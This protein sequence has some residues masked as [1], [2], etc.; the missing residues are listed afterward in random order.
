[1]SLSSETR[2]FSYTFLPFFKFLLKRLGFWILVLVVGLNLV[3]FLPRLMPVSPV[4]IFLT[5]VLGGVGGPGLTM[6]G[7]GGGAA[8]A[9]V[10][11]IKARFMEL[12]GLNQP[13]AIQYLLFWKRMLTLDF[14]IS[15]IE[16]P[17]SVSQVVLNALP[18]TL[19]LIIPALIVGFF[20]GT[21]LG[22]IAAVRPSKLKNFVFYTFVILLQTPYY[23][24][25]M[26]FLYVFAVYFRIF[27]IKGAFSEKWVEPV[28][29]WEFFVDVLW[30]YVLPF[31]T[32]CIPTI[33][34]YAAGMR[35]AVASETRSSYVEFC[36]F[37]GFSQKRVMRYI[38]RSAILPNLTWFPLTFVGLISQTLLVEIVFGYPGLGFY[39]YLAAFSLDYPLME[40]LFLMIMLIVVFG[41]LIIELLYGLLNPKIGAAYVSE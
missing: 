17:K 35:A 25:A 4:D 8:G 30:H 5:R 16:Y 15:Y 39:L 38:M 41:S 9:K 29:S 36:R 13:P 19:S 37:L 6:G 3:F 18:W 14:G 27:P 33:G 7:S 20:I 2:S 23:W 12:F 32:L 40:A 21:Y 10:E 22:T 26:I 24:T 28:L 1:M 11:E 31:I 34:G